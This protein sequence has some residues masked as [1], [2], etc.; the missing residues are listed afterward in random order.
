[1]AT[2]LLTAEAMR[3][4]DRVTIEE[5]GIP[6][7]VL[8][9]VAGRGCAE[10]VEEFLPTDGSGSIA[11]FCGKGNNGG[12]GFV[13]ARH[14]MHAG[15]L[16]E[17]F[18]LAEPKSLRG[19]AL[20]NYE[21]FKRIHGSVQSVTEAG[22]LA[23]LNIEG[24]DVILDAM[25]GTGL[26]S[27]VRG[28]YLE[29]IETINQ[30]PV[31]VVA[32]DIPSGISADTGAIMGTALRAAQTVTF[33]QLKVGHAVY[34][35]A[36]HAGELSLV[37]IGIP[38]R[39]CPEGPGSTWLLTDEDMWGR[40]DKREADAHKGRFG[41]L[42]VLAGSTEKPGAA[43]LCCRAAVRAGAGLVTLAGDTELLS[44]AV[45]GPVEYMGK[46][47]DGFDDLKAFAQGKQAMALGPGLGTGKETARLVQDL[48]AN[49]ALPMVVD[50]DGLNN[51][52]GHLDLLLQAPAPRVLTPHPGEMA[53]LLACTSAE[54]QQDRLGAARKVALENNCVVVLKG[55][56]TV[57]ADVDGLAFV[58]PSGNPGMASGGTGDVLTGMLGSLLAQGYSAREAACLAVFLH[59]QAADK[60]A[61]V[62]SQRALTATDIIEALGG[63]FHHFEHWRDEDETSLA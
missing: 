60:V 49:L 50:A 9:E 24:F 19:D 34:P 12:D 57:V 44:R 56:G 2:P 6:G 26:V 52:V 22:M 42:L 63:V 25:L 51:L 58:N 28:L 13:A 16:V 10:A 38:P 41:H 17:V 5:I 54:V 40:L 55:A 4:L 14:L 62:G 53:R 3:E 39:L 15:H 45:T 23:K 11:V 29:A 47:I 18:L 48:V 59:G 7:P 36:K 20:L 21:I 1:M 43:A 46:K 32:V 35:G 31:P 33:A 30:C 8:M 37:D 61:A 27:N